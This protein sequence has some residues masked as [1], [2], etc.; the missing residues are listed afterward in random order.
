MDRDKFISSKTK[1]LISQ[2]KQKEVAYFLAIQAYNKLPQAQEGIYLTAEELNNPTYEGY[3]PDAEMKKRMLQNRFINTLTNNYDQDGNNRKE[4]DV[5]Y[6]DKLYNPYGG[7]GLDNALYTAGKGFGSGNAFEAITGTALSALK[8]A[9]GFLSGYSTAR[10]SSREERDMYNKLYNTPI[11]YDYMAEGGKTN[12]EMMTG[13]YLMETGGEKNVEVEDGEHTKNSQTGAIQEVVG[14]KHDNGGVKVNLPEQSKVLSD[15]TKIGAELAKSFS[16]KYDIK[17]KASHT[18]ADVMDKVNIK[19]GVKKLE[20]EEK[21]YLEKIEKQLKA[22]VD[23]KTKQIN[24]NFLAKE[25]EELEKE[26]E[27]IQP[28]KNQAFEEIFHEQE[29]IP[30]KGVKTTKMQEGGLVEKFAELTGENL[31]ELKDKLS[32]L[33]EE[34]QFIYTNLMQEVV[35]EMQ[36]DKMAE[37]GETAPPKLSAKAREERLDYYYKQL[38]VAGYEGKKDIGEMQ[39]WVAQNNPQE[40]VKYFNENGQPLTAKHVDIIKSKYKDAF[41]TAGVPAN[42]NSADYTSEEKAKLKKALGDK[43]DSNFLLEGFQDNKWDW[44]FPIVSPSKDK[45]I[46]PSNITNEKLDLKPQA[47]VGENSIQIEPQIKNERDSITLDR[48]LPADLP[49]PYILPPSALRGVYKPEVDLTRLEPIKISPESN[50]TAIE[51]QRQTAS[52]LNFLPEAQR[53][54]MIANML[55]T[56]QNASNQAITQANNANAQM[57]FNTDQYNAQVSDKERLLNTQMAQQYEAKMLGALRNTEIDLR[58]FYQQISDQN[59]QNFLDVSTLNLMNQMT[60]NFKSTGADVYYSPSN[61]K[62]LS[63]VS[64]Q[65]IDVSTLNPT[66]Y[67][68][69]MAKNLNKN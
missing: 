51:A 57:Q 39:K 45:T 38:Q 23:D 49:Q 27:S 25:L 35:D 31:E 53:A 58:N 33:S 67:K 63:P 26:K 64:G 15:F 62:F 13:D 6:N 59:R 4:Y 60:P 32:K 1:E 48:M 14:E 61:T 17:L 69:L 34:E 20:N 2:G 29:K 42:K 24:L 55:G 66:E 18:F 44:R 16:K 52:D 19:I 68:A 47:V 65:N 30:K 46:P 41:K 10:A 11:N 12:A 40:V 21:E 28:L 3:I 43:A 56:T 7:V 36:P 50:L 5:F 9:R 8:G 22:T 54:A 37:G